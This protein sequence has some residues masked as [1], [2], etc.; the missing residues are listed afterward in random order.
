VEKVIGKFEVKY[1]RILDESGK[2]DAHLE[3][4]LKKDELKELYKLLV[5]TRVFDETS[6]KLQREGRIGTYA[7]CKGEEATIIASAFAMQKQDW[8][9]PCYRES[10]AYIARGVPIRNLFIHWAGSEDGNKMPKGN[11]LT[12]SIP[13][14]SQPLHAVGIAWAS[15]IRGERACSLT[16]FG[17]GATSE[18]DFHEAM[19]FAGVYKTPTVFICRNNQWA[20]SVPRVCIGERGC[21]TRADTIAQKALAYGFEGIQVDGN[22]VLAVYTAVKRALDKGRAGKGPTLIECMTYRMSSHTTADDPTRYRT[23]K[24]V[25]AWA[26]K[27]PITRFEKY[28]VAKKVLTKANIQ[29][30]WKD[31]QALVNK[32]LAE[33]E[34]HKPN[35]EDMF[36]YV[37]ADMPKN[38]EEQ[39]KELKG[40]GE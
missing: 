34:K 32:E 35:P 14:G 11:N 1:L 18:G 16:F 38:L 20:I 3:P 27:D 10:G 9:I 19:N 40:E 17:D 13:V 8:L 7:Q 21:Q 28:L 2:A 31:S 15:K 26:G 6:L 4:K 37:Y 33:S 30:I 39:M 5:L 29:K 36:K 22:D 24:E 23:E 12:P 25:K